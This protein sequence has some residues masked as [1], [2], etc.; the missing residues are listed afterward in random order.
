MTAFVAPFAGAWIEISETAPLAF[1]FLSHPSRVRGLKYHM[2]HGK[3]PSSPVAP[4][5]GAW[6]EITLRKR[7]KQIGQV[8][9]FA[10]AW[11]EIERTLYKRYKF[12]VA[13]FAGAWIEIADQVTKLA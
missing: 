5:A 8:A 12:K 11:I 3:Q 1:A 13:P 2:P 7:L 6:I 10:G 4:F 9:P